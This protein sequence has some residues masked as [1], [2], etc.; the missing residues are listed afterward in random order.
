M[1]KSKVQTPAMRAASKRHE[2]NITK[3]GKVPVTLKEKKDELPLGPILIGL[4]AFVVIGSAL[5]QMLQQVQ[6]GGP[7][8][9]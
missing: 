1:A 5:F 7:P 8:T 9:M 3:R 6:F 4:L 2:K